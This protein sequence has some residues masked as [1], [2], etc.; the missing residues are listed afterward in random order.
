MISYLNDCRHNAHFPKL[1]YCT[2]G[3]LTFLNI[4]EACVFLQ[5]AKPS[6]ITQNFSRQKCI[7]WFEP[8]SSNLNWL[9]AKH[10]DA[11]MKCA[12]AAN[13]PLGLWKK[14]KNSF[15]HNVV[16]F[17]TP[18]CFYLKVWPRQYVSPAVGEHHRLS[19]AERRRRARHDTASFGLQ[20]GPHQGGA[21]A[22]AQRSSL[23]QVRS[24][25]STHKKYHILACND[26]QLI[27]VSFCSDYRGWTCLHHAAHEGYTQTMEILLSTNPKLLDK[28]DED[29]VSIKI[30]IHMKMKMKIKMHP[31]LSNTDVTVFL[32]NSD[33]YGLMYQN[34][35]LHIAAREGH[36]AAVK[37]LL[38][39]GAELM[40]NKNETSFLHEALQNGRKDVVNAVIDSDQWVTCG[41]SLTLHASLW[42]RC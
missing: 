36:V 16:L 4:S 5:F 12:V 31:I 19:A 15:F 24:K 30:F 11:K 21:A 10:S 18:L 23:P 6:V 38:S 40:L 26:T 7:Y 32:T 14:F 20:R 17:L 42:R 3:L 25:T 35:A 22:A 2:E 27:I 39:R 34:T 37:L 29:G 28:T 13:K 33:C 1:S 41:C 9:W 8:C